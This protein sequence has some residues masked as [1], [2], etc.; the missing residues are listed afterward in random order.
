MRNQNKGGDRRTGR[1]LARLHVLT[2]VPCWLL[3]TGL[4]TVAADPAS[5][6][7]TVQV[8]GAGTVARTPDQDNYPEGAE[9]TLLA[10]P[11]RWYVFSQW[12]DGKTANPRII[13]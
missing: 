13:V 11:N 3:T 5:F 7:V 1:F 9:V 2:I 10:V 12:D 8:M 6:T 4:R